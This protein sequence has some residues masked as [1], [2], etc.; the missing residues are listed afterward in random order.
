M[1]TPD[2]TEEFRATQR[3]YAGAAQARWNDLTRGAV[4]WIEA[5]DEDAKP[6]GVNPILSGARTEGAGLFV[7][8]HTNWCSAWPR[9]SRP[10]ATRPPRPTSQPNR[11]ERP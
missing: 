10:R 11:E 8:Q 2:D 6:L 7:V 3:G 4:K 9:P 5:P 1:A